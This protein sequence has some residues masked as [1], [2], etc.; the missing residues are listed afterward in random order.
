MDLH[1]PRQLLTHVTIHH[2]APRR[3]APQCV[4]HAAPSPGAGA[5]GLLERGAVIG[6]CPP[7]A[8]KRP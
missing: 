7:G 6:L 3:A 2:Y 1:V 8:V 4:L 5:V